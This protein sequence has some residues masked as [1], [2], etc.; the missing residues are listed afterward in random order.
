MMNEILIT[1]SILII[2]QL[3]SY[4]WAFKNQSDKLTDLVYGGTFALLSMFLLFRS[5]MHLQHIITAF[6][7]AVW[8]IRLSAYLFIRINSMNR[9]KRFDEMRSSWS[10]FGKFWLLQ[11]ISIFIIFLPALFILVRSSV[12][13]PSFVFYLASLLSLIGLIVETVADKQ[14]STFK[15]ALENQGKPMMEGLFKWVRFPNYLGEILFWTGIYICSIEFLDGWQHIAII[16]P[17]WIVF[18]LIKVS[19]IPLLHK[20]QLAAY[21]KDASFQKYIKTTAMLIPGVY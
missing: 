7:V 1:I 19:G 12:D 21:G 18:L 2:I 17:I 6:L 9:D 11:T 13:T 14:K 16:S 15:S 4:I 10:S 20:N 8:G 3:F 5:N